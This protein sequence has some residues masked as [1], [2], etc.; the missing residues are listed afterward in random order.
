MNELSYRWALFVCVHVGLGLSWV[1]IPTRDEAECRALLPEVELLYENDWASCQRIGV[2]PED[3]AAR[4]K[5]AIVGPL[6][7]P[8]DRSR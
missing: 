2:R 4:R 6:L 5:R 8:D 7:T 1:T 3:A